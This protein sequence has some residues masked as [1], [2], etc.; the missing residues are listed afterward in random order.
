MNRYQTITQGVIHFEDLE[1]KMFERMFLNILETSG[2]YEDIRSYGIEGS[3]EGVDIYCIDI[4][5]QLRYFIQCK[6]YERINKSELCKIVDRI[7]KGNNNTEGQVLLVIT[8]CNVSKNAYE[9]YET[10]A[11]DKGFSKAQIYDRTRLDSILHL[12]KNRCIK[13]RYLG[14]DID[15]E[16]LARKRLEYA[17][18]GRYLV[19]QKLLRKINI[20]STETIERLFEY[21]YEKFK[22]SEVIIRSIYDEFYPK[23]NDD[24]QHDTWFKSFP[25]NTYNDGIQLN[26][27]PWTNEIIVINPNGEWLLKKEFDKINIHGEHMELKVNIIGNIPF[28]SIVDIYEEGDSYFSCPI[29]YCKFQ[30]ELGP[31]SNICYDYHDKEIRSRILFEKGMR[32]SICEDDYWRLKRKNIQ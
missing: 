16:D 2:L 8:S 19:E 21:P 9:S 26:I 6:R 22:T 28:S 25:Q 12:E 30:G 10:Y 20:K 7:I 18:K 27:A 14:A 31:F 17:K 29:I 4:K 23:A 24:G 1:P 3:D 11:K 13:D 5:S 32:A 15:K